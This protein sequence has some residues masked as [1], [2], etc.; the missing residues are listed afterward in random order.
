MPMGRCSNRPPAAL[1]AMVTEGKDT[2]RFE[3]RPCPYES[4]MGWRNGFTE[5]IWAEDR[6]D[7]EMRRQ[8]GREDRMRTKNMPVVTVGLVGAG[9]LAETRARCYAACRGVVA[10]I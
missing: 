2:G 7:R 4:V 3:H 5:R 6:H 9:F 1:V 8:G 10:E